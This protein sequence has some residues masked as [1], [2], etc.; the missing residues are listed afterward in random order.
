MTPPA[1]SAPLS[2]PPALPRGV[3][4]N[5]VLF[6]DRYRL[7]TLLGAGGMGEV[8]A[9]YDTQLKRDVA[10]KLTQLRLNDHPEFAARFLRETEMAARLK[11]PNIPRI[12]TTES[13]PDGRLFMVMERVNG[14]TL[15]RLMEMMGKV[16]AVQVICYAMYAAEALGSAH[17]AG[18]CHRDIKPE[19]LMVSG[20]ENEPHAWVLDFGI[21][22]CLILEEPEAAGGGQASR[23]AELVIGGKRRSTVMGTL[24]YVPPEVALGGEAD[25]RGDFFQLGVTMYEA[26]GGAKPFPVGLDDKTGALAALAYKDPPR[27][28]DADCSP[29]LWALL[30]RLVAKAP[31]ERPGSAEEVLA[32]LLALFRESTLPPE[33]APEPAPSEHAM[34]KVVVEKDRREQL[35]RKAFASVAPPKDD[36]ADGDAAPASTQ[37]GTEPMVGRATLPMG[38]AFVKKGPG[39]AEAV[40]EA[41]GTE[42]PRMTMPMTAGIV[43]SPAH[44]AARAQAERKKKEAPVTA[45]LGGGAAGGEAWVA[46]VGVQVAVGASRV[47]VPS[48]QGAPQAGRVEVPRVQPAPRLPPVL[49]GAVAVA[50][51]GMVLLAVAVGMIVGV[52]YGRPKDEG[53]VASTT[54]TPQPLVTATATAEPT[55]TAGPTATAEPAA[56]V[57][58]AAAAEPTSTPLV[59]AAPAASARPSIARP[60]AVK[61]QKAPEIREPTFG[62]PPA[63]QK[64]AEKPPP[65]RAAGHMFD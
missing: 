40:G 27:L 64:P 10:I 49:A 38:V 48:V 62:S 53:P 63:E 46:P 17:R 51:L 50:V 9:A 25:H 60:A 20:D 13:A 42:A 24:G 2:E 14:I 59:T 3:A 5:D 45:R 58:L 21:A 12:Y 47:E 4:A 61:R 23:D 6:A 54:A 34:V 65:R 16:P 44:P 18:I 57:E 56:T 39:Y 35:V 26:I 15:R 22:K 41:A 28:P 29:R 52:R 30:M 36:R 8:W 33:P 37:G 32:A 19:N 43:V 11:H 55:A 31:E 7:E 1:E